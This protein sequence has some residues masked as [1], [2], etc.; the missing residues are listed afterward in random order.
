MG[1]DGYFP[2][3]WSPTSDGHIFRVQTLFGVLLDSMESLL[4]L[5]SSRYACGGELVSKIFL[6]IDV[7]TKCIECLM[8][9]MRE[10]MC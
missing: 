1:Q 4:S 10:V 6:K 2:N 5:E 9:L 8:V 3:F 7:C